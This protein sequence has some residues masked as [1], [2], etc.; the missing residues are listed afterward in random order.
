MQLF[1]PAD[2]AWRGAADRTAGQRTAPDALAAFQALQ[3]D[4]VTTETA[5]PD[6]AKT[7]LL[8]AVEHLDHRGRLHNQGCL[9]QAGSAR[10]DI[11]S[12]GRLLERMAV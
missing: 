6:Y 12:E 10:A 11:A 2:A 5:D 7:S 8:P 1:P 3:A 9:F 4:L